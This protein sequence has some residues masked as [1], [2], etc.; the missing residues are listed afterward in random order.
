MIWPRGTSVAFLLLV[1]GYMAL[2]SELNV[3]IVDKTILNGQSLLLLNHSVLLFSLI[4]QPNVLYLKIP[5][6]VS[7]APQSTD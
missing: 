1:D 7:G 6:G 5:F 4:D 2:I 3:D